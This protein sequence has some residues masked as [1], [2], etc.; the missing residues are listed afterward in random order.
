MEFRLLSYVK[1]SAAPR[2]GLLV[3][4]QTVLDVERV[5]TALGTEVGGL[6]PTSVLSI[7]ENWDK[8]SPREGS[9]GRCLFS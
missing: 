2:A 4:G 7:L 1:E 3:E 5:L 8:V 6:C 9:R